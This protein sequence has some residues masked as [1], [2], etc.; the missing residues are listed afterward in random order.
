MTS[1]G[2]LPWLSLGTLKLTFNVFSDDQGSDPDDLSV[3]VYNSEN[4]FLFF[5]EI[6]TT[7]ASWHLKFPALWLFFSSLLRRTTKK[8]SKLHIT[9]PNQSSKLL[10]LCE[11]NPPAPG[12]FVTQRASNMDSTSMSWCSHELFSDVC[13]E[14][15]NHTECKWLWWGCGWT[16]VRQHF[17][18]HVAVNL[19]DPAHKLCRLILMSESIARNRYWCSLHDNSGKVRLMFRR[20]KHLIYDKCLQDTYI[21]GLVQGRPNSIANAL[22]LHLSCPNPS[23]FQLLHNTWRYNLTSLNT[24]IKSS[25]SDYWRYYTTT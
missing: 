5:S 20:P 8:T 14:D 13:W 12:G 2:W 23:I 21:D 24:E 11:G 18:P 1:S 15:F 16:P 17:Y 19:G 7:W 10:E 22:E 3:L 25:N 6:S 4:C 9:G